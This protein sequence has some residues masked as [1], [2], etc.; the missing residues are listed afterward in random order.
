MMPSYP[1]YLLPYTQ[2][3]RYGKATSHLAGIPEKAL[4]REERRLPEGPGEEILR[5]LG[6]R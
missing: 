5:E 1:E 2:N 4:R 6:Q 3:P